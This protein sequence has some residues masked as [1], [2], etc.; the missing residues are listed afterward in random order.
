MGFTLIEITVT[1][2]IFVS[3]TLAA[4]DVMITTLR[5]QATITRLQALQDNTRFSM[6]LLTKELRTGANYRNANVCTPLGSSSEI[7]FIST[8]GRRTYYLDPSGSGIVYRAEGQEVTTQD[9][10]ANGPHSKFT[11]FMGD[12][13]FVERLSFFLRGQEPPGPSASDGQAMVTITMALRSGFTL[14]TSVTQRFRDLP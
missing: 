11:E 10:C 5:T 13:V 2:S 7:H 3:I 6:E 4:V 9:Q 12:Q 14:E 8:S 1:M